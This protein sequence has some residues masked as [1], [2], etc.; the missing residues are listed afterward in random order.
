MIWCN[1][2]TNQEHGGEPVSFGELLQK[3]DFITLH[4]PLTD[5]T[6]HMI[7]AGAIAKMKDALDHIGCPRRVIDESRYFSLESGK[8]ASAA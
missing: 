5:T 4:V 7:N 6:R 8:I 1:P 3:A 2:R